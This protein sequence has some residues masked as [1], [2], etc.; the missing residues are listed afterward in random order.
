MVLQS[1]ARLGD[2]HDDR[3]DDEQR[4]DAV[5]ARFR[6][7]AGLRWHAGTAM[8]TIRVLHCNSNTVGW[9]ADSPDLEGWSVSTSSFGESKAAAEEAVR[10]KLH[11]DAFSGD[12]PEITHHIACSR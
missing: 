3:H 1:D 8:L 2:H 7:P 12:A 9:T 4:D 5:L 11:A 10:A 6:V